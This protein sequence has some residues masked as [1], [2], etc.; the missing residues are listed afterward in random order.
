MLLLL[1]GELLP[2]KNLT[3]VIRVIKLLNK[4]FGKEPYLLIELF[5]QLFRRDFFAALNEAMASGILVVYSDIDGYRDLFEGGESC[6][7]YS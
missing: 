3:T 6:E 5:C 1:I 4:C 7:K 2:R